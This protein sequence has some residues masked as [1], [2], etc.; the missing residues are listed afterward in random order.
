MN[1]L[2]FTTRFGQDAE[3]KYTQAGKP[4][5]TVRC[6]VDSGWGDNKHTSW[7][8]VVLFGERGEKLCPH[9][10]KGGKATISGELRVREFERNDGSKG[11]SVE[12][13]MRE[14]ELQGDAPSSDQQPQQ[15]RAQAQGGGQPPADDFETDSDIP[16]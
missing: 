10:R 15:N 2:T 7:L 8:T 1:I 12:V 6:P 13:I 5:T 4:I 9:M 14:I 11:T 3:T 16:F